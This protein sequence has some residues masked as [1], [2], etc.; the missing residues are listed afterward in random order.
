MGTW[1]ED[2]DEVEAL[3]IKQ[4]DGELH[5]LDI[6]QSKGISGNEISN[7]PFDVVAA[8]A[9]HN[10]SEEDD[11]MS[12]SMGDLSKV[13][14][15]FANA[16]GTLAQ[17]REQLDRKKKQIDTANAVANMNSKLAQLGILRSQ[18]SKSNLLNLTNS[19]PET[20]K[21]EDVPVAERSKEPIRGS[22][23]QS[24]ARG[25]GNTEDIP[26]EMLESVDFGSAERKDF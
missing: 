8:A 20:S 9:E 11:L 1:W 15:E 24:I 2:E 4:R 5:R 25:K 7:V 16:N 14:D 26:N 13:A 18:K 21:E 17:E 6:S 3:Y 22:I 10:M 12:L 23:R 19:L